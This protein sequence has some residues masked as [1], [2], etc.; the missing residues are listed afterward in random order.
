MLSI[1]SNIGSQDAQ[2]RLGQAQES[3]AR[4]MAKLASGLRIASVADD[5]S[6]L[7]IA[8][9]FDT[10]VRSYNQASR[11]T[12]DGISM[13]QTVDGALGQVHG[14][15]GRMRELAVQSASGTLSD[16]D[17]V[18]IQSEFAQLQTEITRI[19][20]STSFGSVA[21][22]ASDQTVTLQVGVNSTASD[23][24]DIAIKQETADKLGI[25]KLTVDKNTNAQSAL[26][27][28]D[29]AIKNV[30]QERAGL[31][32]MQNRL[33]VALDNNTSFAKN[34]GAA[35]SRIRD[36]DVAQASGEFARSQVLAQAGISVLA[37]ANQI[38]N[39][40]LSLLR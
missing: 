6:G 21:L 4:T 19:A 5:P 17:R 32:A 16:T 15:L 27:T 8:T 28:L 14:A 25:D 38:P 10:Q 20:N 11:N 2:I 7:G 29:T 31:G 23:K 3:S 34:L 37:Q 26:S 12:N 33:R 36:V 24:I 30:S 39:Q 9:A 1:Y 40:A 18:N 22:L 35:V 13:L